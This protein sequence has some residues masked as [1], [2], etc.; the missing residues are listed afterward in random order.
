MVWGL[1][2]CQADEERTCTASDHWIWQVASPKVALKI[3]FCSMGRSQGMFDGAG[4]RRD[5]M[6]G[7]V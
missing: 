6:E 3:S 1:Q 5:D 2:G 7:G 4:L